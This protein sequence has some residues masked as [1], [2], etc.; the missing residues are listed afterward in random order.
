MTIEK[1]L[2]AVYGFARDRFEE[3]RK[4]MSEYQEDELEEALDVVHDYLV[5]EI[6]G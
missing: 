3:E 4:N 6:Y 2:D 1:A 5:N